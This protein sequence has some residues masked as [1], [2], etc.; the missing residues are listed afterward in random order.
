MRVAQSYR[1]IRAAVMPL[2]S[3][4]KHFVIES[5]SVLPVNQ[6]PTNR[7]VVNYVRLLAGDRKSE[8]TVTA[9]LR[10]AAEA[11]VAM[12]SSEGIPTI[13]MHNVVRKVKQ[14]YEIFRRSN[15]VPKRMR[16]GQTKQSLSEASLFR[17]LF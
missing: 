5:P 13:Q 7:D 1:T 2:R 15:K 14:V 3:K 4:A 11:V 10:E 17:K 16:E 8:R 6:L 9:C 12:W